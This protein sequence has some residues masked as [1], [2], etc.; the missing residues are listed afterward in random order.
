MTE[1]EK[2]LLLRELCA[3]LPYGVKVQCSLDSTARRH[4]VEL[5][6]YEGKKTEALGY[7]ANYFYIN[8]YTSIG[9]DL[10]RFQIRP[11]L[12]SMSSMTDEEKLKYV[13]ITRLRYN[14]NKKPYREL[15]IEAIDWLNEHHFDYRGLIG[16]GLA[17][18]A[19]EGMYEKF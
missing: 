13:T 9:K 6:G 16:M 17:L 18:E 19:P 10:E 15:T 11:Y 1:Q 12:R 14:D 3:R 4:I 7:N 8:G 2:R 5:T